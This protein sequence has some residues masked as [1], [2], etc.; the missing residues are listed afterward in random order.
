MQKWRRILA[1]DGGG[2]RGLFSA[3]VMA[4]IERRTAHPVQCLFDLI[5]GSSS[6]SILALG[7]ALPG[8]D[9]IPS[10]QTTRLVRLFDEAGTTIFTSSMTQ[11]LRSLGGLAS[12][13]YPHRHLAEALERH[14]AEATL[15]DVAVD[16][17]VPCYALEERRLLLLTNR[18]ARHRPLRLCEVALAGSAAEVFFPPVQLQIGDQSLALI[19]AGL[20]V[21]NPAMLG[22]TYAVSTCDIEINTVVVSLGIGHTTQPVPYHEAISWGALQWV[23]PLLE[24][25]RDGLGELIDTQ[26]SQLF[27]YQSR[28]GTHRY[29]RCNHPLGDVNSHMDDASPENIAALHAMARAYIREQS[30]QLD[31]ICTMLDE[32]MAS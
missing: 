16:V 28:H 31:E 11:Q 32:S 22:Y 15:G 9:E 8:D 20:F 21:G 14:F 30:D 29:F 18:D 25:V 26:M 2:I 10:R 3:L 4:E 6:G 24:V 23:W 1:I 5:V 12:P 7:L 17:L 27:S 19:D 13:R